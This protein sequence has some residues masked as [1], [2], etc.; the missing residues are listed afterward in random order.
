MQARSNIEEQSRMAYGETMPDRMGHF[1]PHGG[2]YVAETLMPALLQL[3]A[4]Y[5]EISPEPAFR[6]ELGRL[7]AEHASGFLYLISKTDVTGSA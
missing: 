6:E 3:E 2:R 5:R 7:I 4:A 1:G